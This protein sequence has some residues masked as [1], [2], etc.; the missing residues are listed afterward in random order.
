VAQDRATTVASKPEE[1]EGMLRL[2]A[3]WPVEMKK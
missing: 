2:K 3:R 1:F